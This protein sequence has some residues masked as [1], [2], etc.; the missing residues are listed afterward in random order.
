MRA[1]YAGILSSLIGNFLEHD[2]AG[3]RALE[4]S[5]IVE[6]IPV[7]LATAHVQNHSFLSAFLSLPC[8][9]EWLNL[10]AYF[11]VLDF[12]LPPVLPT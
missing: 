1:D 10:K 11:L 3:Y 8:T 5:V 4:R 7:S 6:I 9:K 2:R 12:L